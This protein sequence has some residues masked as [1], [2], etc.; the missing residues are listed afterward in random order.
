MTTLEGTLIS[1]YIQIAA[2]Q[3]APQ[4]YKPRKGKVNGNIDKFSEHNL[5]YMYHQSCDLL[6]QLGYAHLFK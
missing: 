2:Q 6:S 4:I 3:A 5:M 1:S